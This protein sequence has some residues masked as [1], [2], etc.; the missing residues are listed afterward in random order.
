MI[1]K[2]FVLWYFNILY[3][4]YSEK[5]AEANLS[6]CL[7]FLVLSYHYPDQDF[8]FWNSL[9]FF[10]CFF[11]FL[12]TLRQQIIAK[13]LNLITNFDLQGFNGVLESPTGTGKTLCLLCA[14]LAW[15]ETY[16]ARLQ[17]ERVGEI[18][19]KQY[20]EELGSK[21]KVQLVGWTQKD[22]GQEVF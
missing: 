6:F 4:I 8:S 12:S 17:L 7:F 11:N 14:T 22:L 20:Q 18:K 9:F 19:N 16:T 5:T 21:Y 10:Y 13:G 1:F 3:C 15:R 2:N